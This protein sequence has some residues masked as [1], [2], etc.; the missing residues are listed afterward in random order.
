MTAAPLVFTWVLMR[1]DLPLPGVNPFLPGATERVSTIFPSSAKTGFGSSRHKAMQDKNS[2]TIW[3]MAYFFMKD[4]LLG[5]LY[6]IKGANRRSTLCTARMAIFLFLQNS[7]EISLDFSMVS[8]ASCF[9]CIT[10]WERYIK[11]PHSKCR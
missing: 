4:L 7:R 8:N 11:T 6:Y 2:K 5:V 1:R 3:G 9:I 10:A